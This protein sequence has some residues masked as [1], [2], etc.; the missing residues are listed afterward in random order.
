M[1]VTFWT[2]LYI[3]LYLTKIQ[4]VLTLIIVICCFQHIYKVDREKRESPSD[5][6]Y[7]VSW[8]NDHNNYIQRYA[9]TPLIDLVKYIFF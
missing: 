1:G 5:Q 2:D 7:S 8:N 9:L 6:G 3:K 4:H